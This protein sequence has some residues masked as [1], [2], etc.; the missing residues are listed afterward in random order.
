[1]PIWCEQLATMPVDFPHSML[2]R[3]ICKVTFA[4]HVWMTLTER[5]HQFEEPEQTGVLLYQLPIEPTDLV[6]LAVGIV[7]ALLRSSNFITGKD[8]RN[9]LRKHK[10][11]HTILDLTLAQGPNCCIIRLPFHATIPTHIIIAAI[12]VVFTVG[13]IVLVVIGH[14]II[15]GE[16]IMTGDEIDTVHRH[17]R[18]CLVEI[19]AARHAGRYHAY[20]PWLA[21]DKAADIVTIAP[22]PFGPAIA[23][24]AANLVE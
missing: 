20:H 21:S 11:G 5:D 2:I 24:E 13:L 19:R 14:Q 16:A 18:C 17:M 9:A 3:S 1:M 23:R 22:V 7:I 6:I 4:P 15:Q 12:P 8:H 10:Y